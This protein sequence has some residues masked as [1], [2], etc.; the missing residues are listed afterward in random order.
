MFTPVF[1]QKKGIITRSLLLISSMLGFNEAGFTQT[2]T[3][4]DSVPGGPVTVIAGKQYDKSSFHQFLW[5]RHYREDWATPVKVQVL[6]LDTVNGGLTAYEKGGGRQSKTLRLRNAAGKEYVL[7]S[8][9]KSFGKALPEM[10]QGMFIEKIIND[11]VSIAQPYSA[12]TISPMAEA[13]GIYHTEP[14]IVFIP[15]QKALGE[16]NEEFGNNLYL[17]EQRPDENWEEEENFGNSKKIIGT[18]KMLENIWEKH[19][20]RV[21][22]LAY[23]RAR[24][25]DMFIGDWGRHEDQW[26]WAQVGEGNNEIYKPIPRDR[27]Q[28][29]TKFDGKLLS[30]GISAAG[31]G[32]L[33]SFGPTIRKIDSYNFPARYLDRQAANEPTKQQWVEIAKELQKNLTDAV[34]EDAVRQLPPEI[35][36]ISGQEIIDNL[37][38]RRNRLVDFATDY[39]TFLAREVDITGT[40]EDDF[41]EIKK[42]N[43]NE[44]RVNVYDLNKEGHPKKSP[45]YSRTFIDS[46]TNEI[47][48]YGLDGRD[49]YSLDNKAENKTRIRIIGGP[50]KDTYSAKS[51]AGNRIHIY[52][53]SDNLFNST[54]SSRKHLS[55]DSLVHE[56]NYKGF[57][58]ESS[59]IRPSLFYSSEDHIYT[60][61][62]YSIEKHQ[63]RKLPFG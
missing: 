26:R 2:V 43:D 29:Y 47:R 30:L 39:Y 12:L 37:K 35:F 40:K 58:Y 5:G 19:D 61:L 24:L 54:G 51:T 8:I 60:G 18:E 41:F 20:V 56:Y 38:S 28:A 52:D 21:D 44:T 7:R 17:F 62:K 10:Y 25:F 15:E 32:H 14:R 36:P 11:Q 46:E 34:I 6:Y 4:V 42:L 22:Q 3:V 33:E 9:D 53:N 23:V 13:A 27:D 57:L 49:Q 59:G 55:E 48:I 31:A 1:K 45:Y 63:W 50:G 16:F